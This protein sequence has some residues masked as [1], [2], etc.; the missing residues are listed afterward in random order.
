ML[1]IRPFRSVDRA[2]AVQP[3]GLAEP[4]GAYGAGVAD[5]RHGPAAQG[6]AVSG[7]W[8]TSL[9]PAL[10]LGPLAG[11]VADRFDRRLN[12]IVGDVLRAVLYLSIPLTCRS[13]WSTS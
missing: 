3:G 9:L 11:A 8:L 12:M 6:A 13:A 5:R 1:A 7:V 2:L 10:L 4:A